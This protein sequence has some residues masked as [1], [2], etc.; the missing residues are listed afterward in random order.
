MNGVDPVIL[1]VDGLG[2]FG[3]VLYLLAYF[4]FSTGK[5][6]GETYRYQVLNLLGGIFL[7]VNA[8]YY[9]AYPSVGVNLVW[10]LITVFAIVRRARNL[11]KREVYI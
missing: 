9:R 5:L 4:L 6:A 10:S 3:A 7:I 1:V 11:R 8:V 2:W